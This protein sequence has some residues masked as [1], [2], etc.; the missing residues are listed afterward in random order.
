MHAILSYVAP[1]S[2]LKTNIKCTSL[3]GQQ[4]WNGVTIIEAG[5]LTLLALAAP[6]LSFVHLLSDK[7]HCER[8]DLALYYEN[9]TYLIN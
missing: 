3:K 8:V 1:Q 2:S 5:I 9:G 7:Q 4:N 6:C